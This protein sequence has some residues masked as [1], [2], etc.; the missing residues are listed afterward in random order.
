MASSSCKDVMF[1]FQKSHIEPDRRDPPSAVLSDPPDTDLYV[2]G[3]PGSG[4]FYHQAKI[5][6]KTLIPTVFC[7]FYDFLSFIKNVTVHSKSN[8]KINFGNF[9]L[10]RREG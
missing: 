10:W 4:S 5:V 2:F 7:L 8:K 3:P 6:R 9:F 1:P